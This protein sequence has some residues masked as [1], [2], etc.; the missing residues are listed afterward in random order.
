MVDYLR[1]FCS[2][3][4]CVYALAALL[5]VLQLLRIFT[6]S[7]EYARRSPRWALLDA[8]REVGAPVRRSSGTLVAMA[9]AFQP[10]TTQKELHLLSATALLLRVAWLVIMARCWDASAGTVS[11]ITSEPLR[12]TFYAFD[13]LCAVLLV[14]VYVRVALFWAELYYLA[15][16][17]N[18]R[19]GPATAVSA[20]ISAA[21]VATLVAGVALYAT[22]WPSADR[23]APLPAAAAAA[24]FF[25]AA[26]AA[27]GYYSRRAAA[28]LKLV[29][30][31]LQMRRRR[32]ADVGAVAA[33]LTA[34]AVLRA[35]ALGALAG[36]KVPLDAPAAAARAAAYLLALELTPLLL[37]L[38]HH[39]RVPLA[40]RSV[41]APEEMS[42]MGGEAEG[43]SGGGRSGSRSGRG[44]AAGGSIR[45]SWGEQSVGKAVGAAS[46]AIAATAKRPVS[47]ESTSVPTPLRQEE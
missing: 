16:D 36:R 2:S 21:A 25:L 3:L 35:A 46:A 31:E 24:A 29:P 27:L 39:R 19:V 5:T 17:E 26:G 45:G 30:I 8:L 44:G 42:L 15:T 47:G 33:A 32:A 23:Y 4:G 22:L 1:I 9:R 38:A 28:E 37:V 13:G 14:R 6:A 11:A 40:A 12:L 20:A 18:E 7:A 41:L 43:E 10:W 34:C